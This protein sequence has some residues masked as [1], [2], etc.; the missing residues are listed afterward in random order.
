MSQVIDQL[1]SQNS[2]I[3]K[4]VAEVDRNVSQ[5]DASKT[6]T[7]VAAL[8]KAVSG[9]GDAE[10]TKLYPE[11]QKLAKD[12]KLADLSEAAKMFSQNQSQISGA[13]AAFSKRLEAKKIDGDGLKQGWASIS[14]VL[15]SRLEAE[16]ASLFPMY[17]AA[18]AKAG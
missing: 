17:E 16:E 12:R 4:L 10:Q 18:A 9:H 1:K 3:R 8:A 11:M 15:T 7:S 6:A 5:N 13:L 14:G 2:E